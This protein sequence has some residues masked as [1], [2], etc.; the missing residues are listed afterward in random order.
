MNSVHF[1][2]KNIGEIIFNDMYEAGGEKCFK[3][4]IRAKVLW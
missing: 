1:L 2:M 3:E 4:L